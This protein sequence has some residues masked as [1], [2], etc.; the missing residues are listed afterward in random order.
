[1]AK[2][3]VA[4]TLRSSDISSHTKRVYNDRDFALALNM[5]ANL[6]DPTAG[7][8]RLYW[9]KNYRVGLPF[10]NTSHYVN[11]EVDRLLEAAQTEN[12][13]KRVA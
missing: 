13:N 2:I 7:V 12:D 5:F 1:M 3:G 4:V 6:Y 11:P 8:Q 10:S 9:S